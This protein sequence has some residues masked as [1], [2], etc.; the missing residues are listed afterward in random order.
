[1]SE[2]M[3]MMYLPHTGVAFPASAMQQ[4]ISRLLAQVDLFQSKSAK[5]E[6]GHDGY[7]NL[8]PAQIMVAEAVS[9]RTVF[10]IDV[11]S[12]D[13]P[14]TTEQYFEPF[15][16]MTSIMTSTLTLEEALMQMGDKRRSFIA[17]NIRKAAE[18][19]NTIRE[20]TRSPL[21]MIEDEDEEIPTEDDD[22]MDDEDGPDDSAE[23]YED[24]APSLASGTF[25]PDMIDEMRKHVVSIVEK[26]EKSLS[27]GLV[28]INS[29]GGAVGQDDDDAEE[30]ESFSVE[31]AT[32]M[33]QGM[34]ATEE[35]IADFQRSVKAR[36][37]GFIEAITI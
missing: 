11:P 3:K 36:V 13:D 30:P 7:Y 35:Q 16:G 10:V 22:M 31:D 18:L 14:D 1:M 5:I 34:G 25:A 24:E 23:P 9:I 17:K 32:L 37:K 27:K 4:P 12:T 8:D 29:E 15:A 21:E 28:R 19:Q 33:L 26:I 20:E 2:A 6:L